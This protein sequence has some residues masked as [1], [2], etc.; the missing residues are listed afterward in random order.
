MRLRRC[1][2]APHRTVEPFEP[3]NPHDSLFL[4]S[5]RRAHDATRTSGRSGAS[6]RVRRDGRGLLESR[7]HRSAAAAR[8]SEELAAYPQRR[9]SRHAEKDG[10]SRGH[11]R[12]GHVHESGVSRDRAARRGRR[13]RCRARGLRRRASQ[14]SRWCGHPAITPRRIAPWASACSTTSRSRR[15]RCEP[16]GVER[17][18]IVD[19][20]VHHGNGTQNSFYEDPTVLYVSTHQ[21]PYY[22]GTGAARRNRRGRRTWRHAQRA[23]CRRCDRRRLSRERTRAR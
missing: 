18:A 2:P 21:F 20:D 13:G 11:A 12:S 17:V 1:R 8:H 7:R 5:F 4:P 22:P 9:L 19:I 16:S 15:R 23:A 3:S 14:R 10:R 6:R